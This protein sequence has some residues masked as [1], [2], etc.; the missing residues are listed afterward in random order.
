MVSLALTDKFKKRAATALVGIPIVLMVLF[1]GGW[2]F[3]ALL[4][5]LFFL[6]L[7]EWIGMTVLL[8]KTPFRGVMLVVGVFYLSLTLLAVAKLSLFWGPW[9]LFLLLI[10]VWVSDTAAYLTGKG[11]GG[12]KMAPTISPNKTWAGMFGAVIGP[13]IAGFVLTS[14]WPQDNDGLSGVPYLLIG[15]CLGFT[16]QCGD[17]MISAFKRKVGVKD[18]SQILPGHGG[19]L[20]RID[21]LLLMALVYLAVMTAFNGG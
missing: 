14:I 3:M 10:M 8:P 9:Y 18:T 11:I 5:L 1:H 19:V 17:L 12:P 6:S 2:P 4:Y 20:D 7:W 16:G 15:A 21:A 13:A